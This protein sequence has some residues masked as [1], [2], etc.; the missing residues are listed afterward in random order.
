[1][2]SKS[3]KV[4]IPVYETLNAIADREGCRMSE[5]ASAAIAVGIET[6]EREGQIRIPMLSSRTKTL[7][8]LKKR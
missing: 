7:A 2:E 1:M 8:G 3:V 4:R 6:W 5:L